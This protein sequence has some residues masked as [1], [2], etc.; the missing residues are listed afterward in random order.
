M[1]AISREE[2]LDMYE[3]VGAAMRVHEVLHRGLEESVY[4]EALGIEFRR[5][6]IEA[7][8]QYPIHCYY[9]GEEMNK[10]FIADYYYNGVVVELKSAEMLCSEHR[11]QLFNYMRLTN[12]VRGVLINF[13]EK[14]LRAERF[15]YDA[16]IDDFV[17]L[18]EVNYKSHISDIKD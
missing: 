16:D 9:D 11:A 6:G 14:S 8:P 5:R 4:Q 3:V 10:F 1:V 13:G 2:Y 12:S 17:L 18:S 7:T 15:L